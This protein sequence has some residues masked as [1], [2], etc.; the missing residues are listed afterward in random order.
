MTVCCCCWRNVQC[1]EM[2]LTTAIVMGTGRRYNA[3]VLPAGDENKL[4]DA[5]VEIIN[6]EGEKDSWA[7][8]P[9]MW[10]DQPLCSYDEFIGALRIR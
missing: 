2:Q 9:D 4:N 8:G 1:G 6:E 3:K 10:D 5:E 7:V